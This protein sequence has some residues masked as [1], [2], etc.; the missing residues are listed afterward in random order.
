M[1]TRSGWMLK[2]FIVCRINFGLCQYGR[3]A[4]YSGHKGSCAYGS[5]IFFEDHGVLNMVRLAELGCLAMDVWLKGLRVPE[6]L[7]GSNVAVAK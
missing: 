7:D 1:A 3:S 5:G 6:S 2:L 4:R